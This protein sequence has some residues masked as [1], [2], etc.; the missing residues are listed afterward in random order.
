MN[1]IDAFFRLMDEQR[2]SHL[3]L[4]S[5]RQPALRIMGRVERVRYKKYLD[6]ELEDL[7]YAIVPDKKLIAL[8]ETGDIVFVYEIPDLGRYRGHL[9]NQRYG[10]S[11]V[12]K[13]FRMR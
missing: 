12:F 7:L 1:K 13:A 4:T 9:Y 3:F 8:Q 2:A 6:N 5:G 10:I 11:A